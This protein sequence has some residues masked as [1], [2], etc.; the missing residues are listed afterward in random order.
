MKENYKYLK[1]EEFI[2]ILSLIGASF[3]LIVLE[4]MT[5]N[6]KFIFFVIPIFSG[7]SHIYYEKYFKNK[8]YIL[9]LLL[10][11]TISTAAWYHYH[12]IDSR[13]F[14]T[15]EKSMIKNSIDAKI[16]DESFSKLKWITILYPN[17]PEEEI[18]KLKEAIKILKNDKRKIA[19]ITDY[20]FISVFLNMYDNSPNRVWHEG[21]NYP[22]SD[23]K[24]FKTYKN[25]FIN[26]LKENR[27][28]VA[29]TIMPLWGED[30][31]DKA[32]NSILN[33]SCIKKTIINDFLNSY[34]IENCSEIKF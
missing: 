1:S 15:L 27:V 21:A 28:K 8:R 12:Y 7:F 6:E 3:A 5:I 19:I 34:L 33:E 24:Y 26:K 10:I 20:Q 4:L 32:L 22:F 13:K 31:P 11:L 2:I 30:S 18:L 25:F 29:Y 23:N 16:L 9:N 17:D 14:L